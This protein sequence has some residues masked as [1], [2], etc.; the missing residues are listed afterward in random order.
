MDRSGGKSTWVFANVLEMSLDTT[1]AL[2]TFKANSSK[3]HDHD[4]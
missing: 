1:R 3:D 4:C 2:D